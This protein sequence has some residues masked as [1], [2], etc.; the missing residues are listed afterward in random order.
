L[1]ALC[2][3]A[4]A[5]VPPILG[6]PSRSTAR[7]ASAFTPDRAL[8]HH[9]LLTI[10]PKGLEANLAYE[11]GHTLRVVHTPG[12]A[13]NHVCLILLQDGL[14]FSGDHILNGSTTVVDPPDGD[15]TD[16]LASLDLL[17]ALCV[18]HDVHFILP[19]HGYAMGGPSGEALGVIDQLKVHR[20]A[21]EAKVLA[22]M[23]AL[24]QGTLDDWLALVYDDVPTRLWPVAKRSLLAHV[25]RLQSLQP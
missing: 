1:Q 16:Y 13:A 23:Q 21:R 7:A 10:Y 2:Q 24:P 14:L 8:Q 22:A 3:D 18:E 6:L 5:P 20:L 19:A 12:H 17:R 9:E 25:A 4:G 11:L 15:M